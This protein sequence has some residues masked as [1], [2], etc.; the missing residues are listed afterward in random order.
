MTQVDMNDA[1]AA[2]GTVI[3]GQCHC[4]NIAYELHWPEAG[5]TIP[6]RACGCSFCVKHGGNY[7]SHSDARLAAVVHDR[8]LLSKYRFGTETAEFYLCQRC[9]V[10]PF[11][12]SEIDGR[13]YYTG[14]KAS[15]YRFGTETAEFYLCQRCGVVPFITSEIDGR[16]YAVVSVNSFE[17][18]DPA[19]FSTA[20]ADFDG[21][22][23]ESRLERRKSKWI[24][25]VTIA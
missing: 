18:I 17:G 25:S 13:L 12:T 9:G 6:T 4:G 14:G 7:T 1:T 15:K 23:T 24:P 22:T 16:L 19:R 5:T 21:E 2:D 8:G 3:K 10:V 20:A 11:I